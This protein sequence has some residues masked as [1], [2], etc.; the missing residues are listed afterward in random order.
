M[1]SDTVS[2]DALS[3][4]VSIDFAA[5]EP[6]ISVCLDAKVRFGYEGSEL[7]RY[8]FE[9]LKVSRLYALEFDDRGD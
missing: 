2:A 1:D 7:A 8:V 5:C 3:D 6:L 9:A 4:V